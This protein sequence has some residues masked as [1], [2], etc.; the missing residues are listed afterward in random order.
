MARQVDYYFSLASPWA[1]LG[2]AEFMALAAAHG[3]KVVFRP[4]FLRDLFDQT[5]GLP[6]PRRHPV[7][8]RYRLV[9]LQRWRAARG[10]PLVLAPRHVPFD[11][12]P[13]DRVAVTLADDAAACDAYVRA[14]FAAA[15]AEERDL[16]DPATLAACVAAAGRDP[17]PVLTRAHS[18]E[19]GEAYA[20]NEREALAAD[21]FGSPSYVLDGEVFWGQDRLALLADALAS[22]RAP[23]R[24]A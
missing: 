11:P 5:G 21:V 12:A 15:F 8:Q 18:A 22:G 6:L 3:A 19:I 20:R 4:V 14:A 7:R 23:Y 24:P 2:H 17:A 16:A 1:Y 13:P 10:L 9:D